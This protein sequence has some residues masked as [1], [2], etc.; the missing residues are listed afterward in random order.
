MAMAAT[1]FGEVVKAPCRAGTEDEEEEEGRRDTPDDREVR[2]QLARKRSGSGKPPPRGRGRGPGRR[3]GGGRCGWE[4]RGRTRLSAAAPRVGWRSVSGRRIYNPKRAPNG[5]ESR[6]S[7]GRRFRPGS[8]PP[9][10]PL[11]A[12][13]FCVFRGAPLDSGFFKERGLLPLISQCQAY[14]V[15]ADQPPK[16]SAGTRGE[17]WLAGGFLLRSISA[18]SP[19][20]PGGR[21]ASVKPSPAER[22]RDAQGGRGQD[23]A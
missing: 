18:W 11:T 9:S 5:R 23:A 6:T 10:A 17:L 1:F 22:L 7:A 20:C 19:A 15:C 4:S 13:H 16:A 21:P 14:L 3:S 8:P 12:L 2:R